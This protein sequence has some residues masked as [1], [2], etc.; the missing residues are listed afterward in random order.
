MNDKQ[1]YE[2]LA[3]LISSRFDVPASSLTKETRQ[4]DLGIDSILLVDLMLDIETE[5]D[6][7]FES[8]DLPNNPSLGEIV[9]LIRHNLTKTDSIAPASPV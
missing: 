4:K 8:I 7:V 5:L 1:I 6:F 9:A 3:A 2:R